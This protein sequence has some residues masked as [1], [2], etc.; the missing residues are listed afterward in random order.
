M[1]FPPSLIDNLLVPIHF[2]MEMIWWAGL[3]PWEFKFPF[4][5]SPTST[6]LDPAR[7]WRLERER[8]Y[9]LQGYLAHNKRPPHRTLQ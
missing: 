5:G 3:V 4:P 9:A 1:G 6:F 7:K 2:I 8:A